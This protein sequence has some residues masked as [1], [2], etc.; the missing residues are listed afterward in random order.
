MYNVHFD[1]DWPFLI[2]IGDN[3]TIT[4][5][6]L[7]THDASTWPFLKKSRIGGITIGNNVFI[8]H[9]SI[10]LPN[11]R[12]GDNVIIGAGS[13]VTKDIPSDSIAAGNPCKVIGAYGDYVKK[14]EG[15]I[16]DEE[17]HPSIDAY[18]SMDENVWSMARQKI[19]TWGYN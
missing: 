14:H 2:E 13:V 5:S 8:G 4:N 6:T 18:R 16:K 1:P 19:E 11:V 15:Y 10:I 17:N 9:G 3:V 12:I 7:L